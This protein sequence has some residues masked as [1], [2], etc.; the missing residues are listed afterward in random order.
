MQEIGDRHISF[1]F[2]NFHWQAYLLDTCRLILHSAGST[3]Q[4][5]SVHGCGQHS[6]PVQFHSSRCLPPLLLG[7]FC[8]HFWTL[9]QSQLVSGWQVHILYCSK[10]Q[11]LAEKRS[12]SWSHARMLEASYWVG[13]QHCEWLCL[14]LSLIWIMMTCSAFSAVKKSRF[15]KKERPWTSDSRY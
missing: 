13:P 5:M 10:C 7:G 2:Q 3:A 15:L 4:W 12:F 14:S 8:S 9:S 6:Y 1:E 11:Q